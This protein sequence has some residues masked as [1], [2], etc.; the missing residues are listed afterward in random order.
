MAELRHIIFT[1]N[2]AVIIYK[3]YK[4]E[5]IKLNEITEIKEEIL[6]EPK[7]KSKTELK[8]IKMDALEQ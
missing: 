1:S 2:H 8:G 5:E 3:N 6:E 4:L 7:G